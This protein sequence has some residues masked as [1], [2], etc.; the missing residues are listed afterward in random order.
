MKW[1]LV[2]IAIAILVIVYLWR[3]LPKAIAQLKRE[4]KQ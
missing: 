1:E 2:G 4:L 3:R